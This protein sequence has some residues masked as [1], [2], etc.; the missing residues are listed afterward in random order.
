[1]PSSLLGLAMPASTSAAALQEALENAG[2][3][4]DRQLQ[5]DRMYPDLSELLMVSA[6]NNPTVSG[7]SDMDYPLQ[8]PGLLSVPSL[9]E[10]SSIR[11]VPLPPELVEQFGRILL[12]C[13]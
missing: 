7:M 9:P 8:G 5:E 13:V 2:R 1:M 10:I 11:R 4:I 6:P 3:L 12:R